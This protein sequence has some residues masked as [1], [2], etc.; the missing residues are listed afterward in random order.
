MVDKATLGQRL[1][2]LREATGL[3]QEQ[4]ADCLS[5]DQS[6]VMAI[7]A[8][9]MA[10][11]S[12]QIEAFCDIV[13]FPVDRLLDEKQDINPDDAISYS[14]AKLSTESIKA[15]SAVNRIFLNQQKMDGLGANRYSI[16]GIW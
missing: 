4:L 16:F 3:S 8:G 5:V 2:R 11:S 6:L 7:E 9:E 10:A 15:L 13:C 12:T 1:R 14:D